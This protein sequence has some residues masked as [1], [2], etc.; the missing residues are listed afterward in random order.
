MLPVTVHGLPPSAR[1]VHIAEIRHM[2]RGL[3]D[4]GWAWAGAVCLLYAALAARTL[5]DPDVGFPDADRILMDG[6]FIR[7]FVLAFPLSAPL[8]FAL[9]YF[10]QY[11]ALSLGYRPPL[12]P[13]LEA[14]LMVPLGVELWAARLAV[15]LSGVAGLAVWFRLVAGIFD[16]GTAAAACAILASLPFIVYWSSYTMAEVPTM[17]MVMVSA[18]CFY[19]FVEGRRP[20]QLYLAALAFA[21]AVWTKQTAIFLP[22]WL[23]PFALWR[24]PWRDVLG[25]RHVWLAMA[26][27]LVL[28][29]PIVAVTLYLGDQQIAQSVGEGQRAAA[30]RWTVA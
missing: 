14:A 19:W 12:L 2:K 26:L 15:I 3:P 20:I 16:R 23:V 17:A 10:A 18:A 29:A 27:A 25:S 1:H 6:V 24:W 8:D 22:L 11:P 13:V 28:I 21:A 4:S 7:D 5:A 30:G 9:R